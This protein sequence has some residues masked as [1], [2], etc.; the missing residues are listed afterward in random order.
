MR[1]FFG[2]LKDRASSGSRL[3]KYIFR[4]AAIAA[5]EGDESRRVVERGREEG[6]GRAE[7]GLGADMHE[8]EA[9]L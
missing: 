6:E 2:R 5:D 8:D 9:L 1:E 4:A 7:G 3:I